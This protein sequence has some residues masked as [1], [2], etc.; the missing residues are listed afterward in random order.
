MKKCSFAHICAYISLAISVSMLVLWCCNAKGF[1]V[2][3]LDS[4]VG[5]IVAL[6]AIVVTLVLGWQIF[7]SIEIKDKI[8]KLDILKE[9]LDK[10]EKV[11]EENNNF[12]ESMIFA[13][14]AEIEIARKEYTKAYRYL[15]ISLDCSLSMDTPE[16]IHAILDRMDFLITHIPQDTLCP[17][18]RMKIIQDKDKNIRK[19]K[20]FEIIKDQYEEKYNKFISK[21]KRT[22]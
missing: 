3:S 4:F 2:V 17:T 1:S 10:Q 14:L 9:K 6:L 5:V 20:F 11:I 7:N 21:V 13:S 22:K 8:K 16:N 15:I 19:S 12:S 18:D